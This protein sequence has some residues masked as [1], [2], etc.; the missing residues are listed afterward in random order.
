MSNQWKNKIVVLTAGILICSFFIG[1]L[2]KPD[3]EI[4]LSER[5]PLQQV[6]SV[7]KD[8]LRSGDFMKQFEN[9]AVD[10]FPMRESFRHL[11][12]N[13]SLDLLGKSD[14]EGLYF[15]NDMAIAME[16]PMRK[17]SLQYSSEV[18]QRI[19]DTCLSG[20]A[21]NIYLSIIPDKNYFL[22]ND[23]SV[24]TMDY[25]DFFQTMQKNNPQMHYIDITPF[26]ELNDYYQT[27]PHWRQERLLDVADHLTNT[28]GTSLSDD[29]QKSLFTE[30]FRG[31]Y[32]GQSARTLLGEPLYY[33]TN[34][35]LEQYKVFDHQ[36][37]RAISMY[38]FVKGEGRDPYELFLSGALSY[39]TIEN[40]VSQTNQELVIFRDSFGSS[41]APLLATG[42]KKITL[43]DVR[44][45][46][47]YSLPSL[48]DFDHQDVLFLYSTSVLN[49]SETLK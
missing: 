28:M 11:Y 16:Y 9:Y 10:Q 19:Y 21:K 49:H 24:L 32:A 12:S 34:P 8:T 43:L 4:S 31:I 23:A 22:Q 15:K 38:D 7:S 42:Y 44:Y 39:I 47:S 3:E 13:I 33:L 36:N 35:T 45:L 30:G 5:R 27:D 17:N 40:P 29:F 1:S 25:T 37:N 41:I 26:L 14:I 46:P 6:P 18:F 48:V 2:L 20:H